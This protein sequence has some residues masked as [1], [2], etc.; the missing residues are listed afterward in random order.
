MHSGLSDRT[1]GQ[2]SMVLNA[3]GGGAMTGRDVAEI[4]E[5][6]TPG[7]FGIGDIGDFP[8]TPPQGAGEGIPPAG[9]DNRHLPLSR[10]ELMPPLVNMDEAARAWAAMQRA[11]QLLGREL[12]HLPVNTQDIGHHGINATYVIKFFGGANPGDRKAAL[13]GLKDQILNHDNAS[14]VIVFKELS[15]IDAAERLRSAPSGSRE[16]KQ[17]LLDLACLE[18]G[19]NQPGRPGLLDQIYPNNDPLITPQER[20]RRIADARAKAN[21][22][23][24]APEQATKNAVE[25]L[26]RP[27]A[28]A[29]QREDAMDMLE[30]TADYHTGHSGR[31]GA[32]YEN[33]YQWARSIQATDHFRDAV[34]QT[35]TDPTGKGLSAA[36][37]LRNLLSKPNDPVSKFIIESMGRTPEGQKIIAAARSGERKA[38]ERALDDPKVPSELKEILQGAEVA[39]RLSE[40]LSEGRPY[41]KQLLIHEIK[42]SGLA[43]TKVIEA[44]TKG[45]TEEAIQ[46]LT[47]PENRR[48]VRQT[49]NMR[50]VLSAT[51]RLLLDRENPNSKH[52]F[53]E[54][55]KTK[56][57]RDLVAAFD[58]KTL[59]IDRIK[60][61]LS[62]PK[63]LADILKA[64]APL[65]N[66]RQTMARQLK[67]LSAQEILDRFDDPEKVAAARADAKKFAEDNWKASEE[68]VKDL[69]ERK[70]PQSQTR[71][72][73]IAKLDQLSHE[74]L[75]K[76]GVDQLGGTVR[77]FKAA[78]LS[79]SLSEA[80]TAEET[81][82]ALRGLEDER[83]RGNMDA[84]RFLQPFGNKESVADLLKKIEEGDAVAL[85][86]VK[87]IVSVQSSTKSADVAQGLNR[88]VEAAEKGDKTAQAFI[89]DS[90]GYTE[91]N[92]GLEVVKGLMPKLNADDHDA[93]KFVRG[94][95]PSGVDELNDLRTRRILHGLDAKPGPQDYDARID[96]LRAEEKHGNRAAADWLKWAETSKELAAI[97][98]ASETG[99]PKKAAVDAMK[100]LNELAVAGN[101]YARS[102]L[103][104]ALAA[105]AEKDRQLDYYAA[106]NGEVGLDKD[107]PLFM[108]DV[109]KLSEDTRAAIK[110]SALDGI[111]KMV[112]EGHHLT[113]EEVAGLALAFSEAKRNPALDAVNPL[114]TVSNKRVDERLGKLIEDAITKGTQADRSAAMKA[115]YEVLST[116]FN[117][118]KGTKELADIFAKGYKDPVFTDT[119]EQF[120]RWAKVGHEPALRIIAA[121]AGGKG[122]ETMNK[123]AAATL[124]SWSNNPANADKARDLIVH[125][126]QTHGDTHALL[127]TLGKVSKD[128]KNINEDVRAVLRDGLAARD[129]KDLTAEDRE[130]LHRS[131]LAGMLNIPD[132]WQGKDVK[133]ITARLTPDVVEGLKR[134]ADKISSSPENVRRQIYDELFTKIKI[135]DGKPGPETEAALQ[136]LRSFADQATK[137][138]VS[139]LV[140]FGKKQTETIQPPADGKKLEYQTAATLLAIMT[141]GKGDAANEAY[142]K[143]GP[144][145][146][147][148][149]L[150]KNDMRDSLIAYAKGRPMDLTVSKEVSMLIYDAG[151]PRPT[152]G[153]FKDLGIA[154]TD[155]EQFQFV[156]EAIKKV[157]EKT[158]KSKEEAEKIIRDTLA[159]VDMYNSLPDNLRA[160]IGNGGPMDPRMVVG[161]LANGA[162]FDATNP[163][164]FLTGDLEKTVRDLKA[165]ASTRVADIEREIK[166]LEVQRQN[167]LRDLGAQTKEGVD[168]F[169]RIGHVGVKL[170]T[171]GQADS[172]IDEYAAKQRERIQTIQALEARM[173][174]VGE[175][176]GAPAGE[177]TFYTLSQ[178]SI[179]WTRLMQEGKTKEADMMAVRMWG[180]HGNQLQ[181]YAPQIWYELTKTGN[182]PI[183]RNVWKRLSENGYGQIREMPEFRFGEAAGPNDNPPSGLSQGLKALEKLQ[184]Y[185]YDS[186]AIRLQALQA[187]DSDPHFAKL[188]KASGTF[189]QDMSALFGN[190]EL[191]ITGMFEAGM[192]GTKYAEFVDD[193]RRRAD[194]IKGALDSVSQDDVNAA[195][196]Q[197]I[198]LREAAAKTKDH[199]AAEALRKRASELDQVVKIF[200]RESTE[201]PSMRKQIERMVD[202]IKSGKFDENTFANWL[203]KEGIIYAIAIA[204]AVAT[205]ATMGAASPLL[206]A[207]AASGVAIIA[208]EGAKELLYHANIPGLGP[209]EQSRLGAYI[210]GK[211]EIDPETGRER[212]R[213]LFKD[214]VWPYAKQWA[215][216]TLI[217]LATM[218]VGHLASKGINALGTNAMGFL[219][220]H[221]GTIAR[222]QASMKQ[223]SVAAGDPAKKEFVKKTLKEFADESADEFKEEM[224]QT[225]LEKALPKNAQVLS[226]VAASLVAGGKGVNFH[227]VRGTNFVGVDVQSDQMGEFMKGYEQAGAKVIPRADKVS[228]EVRMPDGGVW[229][230]GPKAYLNN[231]LP[232]A[233]LAPKGTLTDSTQAQKV[234]ATDTP[235]TRA[236]EA[237]ELGTDAKWSPDADGLK[238]RQDLQ[239]FSEAM[240]KGDYKAAAEI[241]RASGVGPA[242]GNVTDTKTDIKADA[243]DLANPVK[244]REFLA[245]MQHAA[246]IRPDVDNEGKPAAERKYEVTTPRPVIKLA[247]GVEVDLTNPARTL[248]TDSRALTDVEQQQVD[249][250]LKSDAGKRILQEH[251]MITMEERLVHLSQLHMG[252]KVISP[253]Y[254]KFLAERGRAPTDTEAADAYYHALRAGQPG[255]PGRN[256]ATYEQELIALLYDSG[257]PIKMI[258]HHFGAQ[259]GAERA[260]IVDY[261]KAR[262]GGVDAGVRPP[263]V[264][265]PIEPPMRPGQQPVLR[266]SPQLEAELKAFDAKVDAT[267]LPSTQ[268]AKIKEQLRAALDASTGDVAPTRTRLNNLMASPDFKSR[269]ESIS[270]ILEAKAADP[271]LPMNIDALLNPALTAAD[272]NNLSSMV[273][274]YRNLGKLGNLNDPQRDALKTQMNER[275]ETLATQGAAMNAAQLNVFR[276]SMG[277]VNALLQKL[278][279]HDGSGPGKE[280]LSSSQVGHQIELLKLSNEILAVNQKIDATTM[281]GPDKAKAKETFRKALE[282]ST[283]SADLLRP[284]L[285]SLALKADFPA[286]IASIN[287]IL[288][289]KLSDSNIPLNVE[290]LLNPNWSVTD[291][292]KIETLVSNFKN[293]DNIKHLTAAQMDALKEQITT[294]L[295]HLADNGASLNA[296]Q[297]ARFSRS[298]GDMNLVTDKVTTHDGSTPAK[299]LHADAVTA[300]LDLLKLSWDSF[301][302]NMDRVPIP[303]GYAR[304][305]NPSAKPEA[306]NLYRDLVRHQAEIRGPGGS[307]GNF[308]NEVAYYADIEMRMNSGAWVQGFE[309]EWYMSF[310][311]AETLNAGQFA[312]ANRVYVAS[313]HNSAADGAGIDGYI[314][315]LDNNKITPMDFAVEVGVLKDRKITKLDRGTGNREIKNEAMWAA[316][317]DPHNMGASL[318]DFLNGKQLETAYKDL[319]RSGVPLDYSARNPG[320][321]FEPGAARAT[322]PALNITDFSTAQGRPGVPGKPPLLSFHPVTSDAVS[323]ANAPWNGDNPPNR[324]TAEEVKA[325]IVEIDAEIARRQTANPADPHLKYLKYLQSR[326]NSEL[327][328]RTYEN[329]LAQRLQT[330]MSDA[331]AVKGTIGEKQFNNVTSGTDATNRRYLEYNITLSVNGNW[332][333]GGSFSSQITSVRVYENGQVVGIATR[334]GR[335]GAPPITSEVE[336]GHIS[337]LGKTQ[338]AVPGPKMDFSTVT[339]GGTKVPLDL[340]N[341]AHKAAFLEQNPQL[342]HL[343]EAR[344]ELVP[345]DPAQKSAFG[346]KVAA[347]IK[348]VNAADVTEAQAVQIHRAMNV[349]NL[350]LSIE[351]GYTIVRAAEMSGGAVSLDRAGAQALLADATAIEK[352]S[353]GTITKAQ[354]I[355][356]ATLKSLHSSVS[357]KATPLTTDQINKLVPLAK[358]FRSANPTATPKQLFDH[359][360]SEAEKETNNDDTWYHIWDRI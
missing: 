186:T 246:N 5:K 53:D 139:A 97:N 227:R 25:V 354:A 249:A 277:E 154:G 165:E 12:G 140:Q 36:D 199:M 328:Q 115:A 114:D 289:A 281:S 160:K 134:V 33:I 171:F 254:A 145:M 320:L 73:G 206:V 155:L 176:K 72:D 55:Q 172:S 40:Q 144:E 217:C 64:L 235:D 104:N 274:S 88:L 247:S 75:G 312:N 284:Q 190:K 57:G 229:I 136:L 51:E 304:L 338:P 324:T 250:L 108:P 251:A 82:A 8:K 151:I 191:G 148:H 161:M 17:A 308:R 353:K 288:D 74:R 224:A 181:N 52:I 201:D 103:T 315:D 285:A 252:G 61:I 243:A 34:R 187:V 214:V 349:G 278:A 13:A 311:V 356:I 321:H 150:S 60:G 135:A 287:N 340:S 184:P 231:T 301:D 209:G 45:N 179:E 283:A 290:A 126:Y 307:L 158:G 221:S 113:K 39:R 237:V 101:S 95:V 272:L 215:M 105:G 83:S 296:A 169:D 218:G 81:V 99:D 127:E 9:S 196:R 142:Q 27:G 106:G 132:Q 3:A 244:L 163:A 178:Q 293:V 23:I 302:T 323:R 159:R 351:E 48:D 352:A 189:A 219:A 43:G 345:L 26:S 310:K 294:R 129:K 197:I 192:A 341:P 28:T 124:E 228:Y 253:T 70:E 54:L 271:K 49:M 15:L 268:K 202:T 203:M 133:L 213:E 266:R 31:G 248:G 299:T 182:R 92:K 24:N 44:L 346:A 309:Y 183:D 194:K 204:A 236:G 265:S 37:S 333:G 297:T 138:D 318:T 4:D 347:K 232:D 223:I 19:E 123:T 59:N 331:A 208:S 193:A 118:D 147:W 267:D 112:K 16:Q 238:V 84:A 87:D 239:K 240:A 130:K 56:A 131:A 205:V 89:A 1:V 260:P 226:F 234:T 100:R 174:A 46:L 109:S 255:T 355:E 121:V 286:R 143:L 10:A 96:K 276:N 29:E 300:S 270:K 358:A 185:R 168:I 7:T 360:K 263:D 149:G 207:A 314:V 175:T 153:I 65:T 241:A 77:W 210:A 259:W 116:D 167:T 327:P 269:A 50:Q 198:Q 14:A 166:D 188:V 41:E 280:R 275:L 257:M 242:P 58:G 47:N 292:K 69:L 98:R 317:L 2:E 67:P 245:R 329:Q 137:A 325:T 330:T 339:I 230:V 63:D 261:L 125:A 298:I 20:A 22:L 256:S 173:T 313:G 357:G 91:L 334:P 30:R 348:G 225:L 211:P 93:Y 291:L 76:L 282:A 11:S 111:E 21:Q 303:I 80:R 295:D 18:Q 220:R 170:F 102:A 273:D 162:I 262:E 66:E 35:L 90:F 326:L 258:E 336:L 156:E 279:H 62:N 152:A 128:H 350:K 316:S 335:G 177:V 222:M 122:Y 94:R 32:A 306:A 233:A 146:D 120:N 79:V 305:L 86:I 141:K 85:Q 68:S 78:D 344:I 180:E 337:K 107:K 216:D 264:Q 164:H 38:L 42:K 6:D 195:K 110:L 322:P 71:R 200:D 343:A 342:A 119:F 359:L 212:P 117:G 319:I 332:P 157:Q